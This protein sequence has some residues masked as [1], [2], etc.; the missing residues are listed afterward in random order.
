MFGQQTRS[1]TLADGTD[2]EVEP[3]KRVDEDTIQVDVT[4]ND[5]KWRYNVTEDGDYALVASWNENDELAN[6]PE[7]QWIGSALELVG[8]RV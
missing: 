7:P 3:Q 5:R 8:V 2:V 6:Q 4:A 1:M